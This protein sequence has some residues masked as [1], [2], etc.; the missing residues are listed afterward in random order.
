MNVQQRKQFVK[1]HRTC[2][3]GYSRDDSGPS[4]SI[5]YYTMDGDDILVSTMAKRAKAKAVDR[6][7]KVSLCILDENWPMTYLVVYGSATLERDVNQ[8]A[9]VMM[10]IGEIMSGNPVPE[11]ARP[12]VMAMAEKEGRLVV[13]LKPDYTFYT[14]PVHLNAGDDGSKLEHGYGQRLNWS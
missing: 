8:T 1:D 9:T 2:V 3:F 11:A 10:K 14:P 5:V 6:L 13:R 7:G 4:M 12:M